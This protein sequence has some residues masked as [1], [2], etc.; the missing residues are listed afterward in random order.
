[1]T[2]P[3]QII[4]L[5]EA[6]E[7]LEKLDSSIRRRCLDKMEWLAR[8]PEAAG[9][10]PLRH[11]PADLRGL[12]SYTVGDWRIL[13]WVYPGEGLVKIYGVEHRSRIYKRLTK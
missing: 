6:E 5:P 8:N 7:D 12:N 1:M 11:L 13:Y 9:R 10:K 2:H 4:I 3:F